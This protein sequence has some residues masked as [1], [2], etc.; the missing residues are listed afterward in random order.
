MNAAIAALCAVHGM[1]VVELPSASV[2]A[3]AAFVHAAVCVTSP[4][5]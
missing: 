1:P 5:A 4:K 3:W 2:A